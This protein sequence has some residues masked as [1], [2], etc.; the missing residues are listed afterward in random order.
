MKPSSIVYWSRVGTGIL[1]AILCYFLGLNE[2]L[3]LLLCLAVFIGTS[4]AFER[5]IILKTTRAKGDPGSKIWTV[6]IGT[7]YILWVMVWTLLN[8][9]LS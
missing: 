7:Y 4:V 5:G 1:V 2:I 9:I 6:G 3:G 8:T